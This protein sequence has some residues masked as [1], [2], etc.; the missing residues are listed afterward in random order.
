MD[1]YYCTSGYYG[2]S[3][4]Q[5]TGCLL[6]E[7]GATVTCFIAPVQSLCMNVIT[8]LL[9]CCL[10]PAATLHHKAAQWI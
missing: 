7:V 8:A 2:C 3:T 9:L 5:N 10:F 6:F 4:V 1:F